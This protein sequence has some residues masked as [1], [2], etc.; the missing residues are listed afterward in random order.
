MSPFQAIGDLKLVNTA[1]QIFALLLLFASALYACCASHQPHAA[2]LLPVPVHNQG[3]L[4]GPMQPPAHC[5]NSASHP[6][7]WLRRD[8]SGPRFAPK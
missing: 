6:L 3:H 4:T 8:F 1:G 7:A 5:S 2:S